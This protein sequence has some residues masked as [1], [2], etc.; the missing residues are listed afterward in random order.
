MSITTIS[1]RSNGS[2]KSL[3]G[4]E[5]YIPWL[6]DIENVLLRNNNAA[7]IRNGSRAVQP[8]TG[9]LDEH[10]HQL[11]QYD[12][13]LEA[14]NPAVTAFEA[15]GRCERAPV[16]PSLQRKPDQAKGEEKEL[17]TWEEQRANAL[18]E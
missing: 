6:I 3:R 10:N 14:Y 5:N 7:Y 4:K 9:Y 16:G 17:K 1:T 2:I 11:E 13:E 15:G 8:S 18:T 12:L